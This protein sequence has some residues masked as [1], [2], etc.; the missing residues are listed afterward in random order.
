MDAPHTILVLGGYGNTG[1]PLVAQILRETEARVI[2]AGRTRERAERAV[3]Q[4]QHDFAPERVEAAVVDAADAKSLWNALSGVDVLVAASSTAKHVRTVASAALAARCDYLDVQYSTAKMRALAS[5]RGEIEQAGRCF[6]A[7]C[8]FHPGLPAALVRHVASQFD[9]L[10]TA[11]VSSIIQIDWDTLDLGR[12]TIDEFV[13]EF[14]DYEA[15]FFKE[16][17]WNSASMWSTKDFRRVD[18]GPPFGE[19]V[20]APMLFEE[21]RSLPQQIPGLRETGFFIAGFNPVTDNLVMPLAIV[22]F[23]YFPRM[24]GPAMARLMHW[25]MRRF[26]RPPYECILRVDAQGQKDGRTMR[27]AIEL[28]HTDGYLMTAIPVAACL[29]QMLIGGIRKPG[30]WTMGNV[31]ETQRLFDDMARMGLPATTTRAHA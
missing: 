31:V 17:A 19:R 9:T 26:A 14:T 20:C 12:D 21:L 6:I 30:L 24:L 4:F 18:F 27:A 8:G 25:S 11:N 15:Q 2:V 10:E 29:K 13:G 1:L 3:A 5:M 22:A 16:G 23:R 7:D 28:R